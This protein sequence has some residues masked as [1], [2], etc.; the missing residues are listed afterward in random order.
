[1]S[2]ESTAAPRMLC[3]IGLLV[4][5][6]LNVPL[7]DDL[8]EAGDPDRIADIA[9]VRDDFYGPWVAWNIVRTVATTAALGCLA[10]ALMLRGRR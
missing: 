3:L 9:A 2:L 7:N 8:A 10:Y 1:M 6:A 5:F 4:T